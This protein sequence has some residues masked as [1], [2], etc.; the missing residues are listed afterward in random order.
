MCPD[1][2]TINTFEEKRGSNKDLKE[3]LTLGHSRT[4][5]YRPVIIV[6][7]ILIL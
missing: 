3:F 6:V 5:G 4:M 2:T 7:K 1:F